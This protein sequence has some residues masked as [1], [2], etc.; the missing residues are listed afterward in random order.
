MDEKSPVG[1]KTEIIA[2]GASFPVV[3]GDLGRDITCQG[4]HENSHSVPSLLRLRG[5]RELAWGQE[6]I[7]SGSEANTLLTQ[8]LSW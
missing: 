5:L 7:A 6:Y 3:L 2:E 1:T 8:R 4:C